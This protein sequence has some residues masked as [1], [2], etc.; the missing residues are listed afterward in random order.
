MYAQHGSKGASFAVVVFLFLYNGT[1]NLANSPF[2]YCYPTDI[3]P[4][5]IRA[6]GL[7]IQVA[8]SQ[9]ARTINQYVNSIALDSIGFYYCIFYLGILILSV[10]EFP[11]IDIIIRTLTHFADFDHILHVSRDQRQDGG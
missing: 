8:V 9:A 2:I 10:S 4:F 6:K 5:Y 7:G 11:T 3:L 1:F